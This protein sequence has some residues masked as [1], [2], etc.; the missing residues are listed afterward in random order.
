MHTT[1]KEKGT[2]IKGRARR[3]CAFSSHSSKFGSLSRSRCVFFF[4]SRRSLSDLQLSFTAGKQAGNADPTYKDEDQLVVLHAVV[5]AFRLCGEGV[6]MCR[7]TPAEVRSFNK[8]DLM[9]FDFC[10]RLLDRGGVEGGEV[11]EE[12]GRNHTNKVPLSRGMK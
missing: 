6:R 12:K 3:A 7:L 9:I 10:T 4:S 2:S 5:V 1:R 11:E 8:H